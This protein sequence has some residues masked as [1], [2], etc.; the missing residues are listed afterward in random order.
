MD[1]LQDLYYYYYYYYYLSGINLVPLSFYENH[2]GLFIGWI[3]KGGSGS[4]LANEIAK[5]DK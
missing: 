3:E 2:T 5:L 1:L 4:S